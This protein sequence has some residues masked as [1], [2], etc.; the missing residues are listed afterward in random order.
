MQKVR[1]TQD[2]YADFTG[3]MGCH[4]FVNGL[5]V[6][7]LRERDAR[8]IGASIQ[9]VYEDGSSVNPAERFSLSFN[10]TPEEAGKVADERAA[11]NM[12]AA[13]VT[14][15]L[16]SYTREGL[17]AVADKQGIKGLREIGNAMGVKATSVAELIDGIL[18]AQV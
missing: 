3:M 1:L 17:E 5:S 18:K 8:F 12:E 9:C 11:E 16:G 15:T 13:G 4:E 14:R 6:K 2:G 10:L 7:E